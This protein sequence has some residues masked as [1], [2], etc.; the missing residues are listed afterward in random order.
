MATLSATQTNPVSQIFQGRL[1][2]DGKSKKVTLVTAMH[3]L[4][5]LLNAPEVRSNRLARDP[6]DHDSNW[7]FKSVSG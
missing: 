6:S 5:P 3:K 1:L 2:Q 4:L 7:T